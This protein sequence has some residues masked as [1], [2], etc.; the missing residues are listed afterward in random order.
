MTWFHPHNVTRRADAGRLVV[1]LLFGV[2]LV[3]FFRIQVIGRYDYKL[4]S[5]GNRLRPVPLPAPRGLIVDRNGVVLADNVPGYSIAILATDSDSLRAT[6]HG[7]T[8][9]PGLDSA[10]IEA[11]VRRFRRF[12]HEP[13]VVM[14]DAPFNLVSALEESRVTIPR[15]HIQAE[16]KR[17]YPRGEIVAHVLGYVGEITESEL[18]SGQIRGARSGSIVGRD[19]LERQYD[20]QLRGTDGRRTFEVTALGRTVIE[21]REEAGLIDPTQGDTLHTTLDVEL[22]TY[23]D[24]VFPPGFSGGVVAM[25]PRSGAVLAL[26]SAPSYDPNE[27]V[28]GMDPQAWRELS[29]AEGQPLFNRAIEGRYAPASPFKLAV[30]SMAL[31][32]GLTMDSHMETRCEGGLLFGNRYFRCWQEDGHGDLSLREAIQYSCDVYFYQL[33]L[34]LSLPDLLADGSEM[35]FLDRSGIDLPDESSPMFPDGTEYYDRRYGPRGWTRG[36]TLNMAIG[37]GENAQ[38]VVNMVKFYAKLA[39]VDG[40]APDPHLFSQGDDERKSL[41]LSEEQ[42]VELREALFL[43]VEEGTA[44]GAR[45]AQL[46][47]AGKT[48]TAQNPQGEPHGWFIGFAPVENPEIVVGAII[49]H[50]EHGSSVAPLVTRVIQKHLLG[51]APS[52]ALRLVLP[53][54]SAPEPLPILPDTAAIRRNR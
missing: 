31:K 41:G 38:S 53:S 18:T 6:L 25:D 29:Q 51:E 35:G 20:D 43:V 34:H 17:R 9:V 28:G 30:A 36:V 23:I 7:L 19:G 8:Q 21:V 45:V 52:G 12:P 32:R 37:Q 4:Q 33:G 11:I 42:L 50:A 1:A 13:A 39:S 47:I 3:G 10:R 27:F 16:P 54:D 14:R 22:Q 2:L 15:L 24:S 46:R 40:A 44:I 26:Y 5:D 48:G 49:E